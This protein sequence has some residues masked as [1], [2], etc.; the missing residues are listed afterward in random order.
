MI[1]KNKASVGSSYGDTESLRKAYSVIDSDDSAVEEMQK[2]QESSMV[3]DQAGNE[4][5]IAPTGHKEWARTP[6]MKGQRANPELCKRDCLTAEVFDLSDKK[7]LVRYNKLL[8]QAGPSGRN[9]DGDPT[10]EIAEVDKQFFEG[11]FYV[12]VSYYKLWYIIPMNS[13]NTK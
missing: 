9:R 10:I 5:L 3:T 2:V 7:D 1:Q 13:S 12:Y 6:F 4:F 11:K 8:R